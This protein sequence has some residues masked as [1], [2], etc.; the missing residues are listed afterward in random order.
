MACIYK[1][2]NLINGKI[3]I[4]QAVDFN[5][6][7]AHHARSKHRCGKYPTNTNPVSRA[8][9][10]YGFENFKKEI[11]EDDIPDDIEHMDEAECCWIAKLDAT[12]PMIGYNS[13]TGG[14]S[15]YHVNEIT[16]QKK[17]E[18]KHTEEEKI[19]RSKGVCVFDTQSPRHKIKFY[20]NAKSVADVLGNT[21][22]EV[23][24]AIK[25]GSLIRGLYIFYREDERRRECY[26]A[27]VEK[28]SKMTSGNGLS[29][30]SL[31]AYCEAYAYVND[32][33]TNLNNLG[34]YQDSYTYR[35]D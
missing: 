32:M 29:K 27:I 21:R 10:K 33:V 35:N 13:S 28:K 11:I 22:S 16:K 15:G 9:A 12:N 24:K 19:R 7:M 20:P 26:E 34:D 30:K 4:G 8:I 18:F 1:L 3:Y 31:N 2:T 25:R 14:H 23:S 5:E 6:R 17:R